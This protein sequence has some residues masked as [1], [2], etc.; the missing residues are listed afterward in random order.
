M[1]LVDSFHGLAGGTAIVILCALG[2]L[3]HLAGDGG[4]CL[5]GLMIR[6]GGRM[7]RRQS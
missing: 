4:A 5:A 6:S 7:T 3:A 2:S 1:K